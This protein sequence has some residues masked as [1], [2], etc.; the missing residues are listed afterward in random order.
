MLFTLVIDPLNSLLIH[1]TR[2][3]I[4]RRL[5]DRH[6]ASSV[7]L[8]ADDVVVF[9][10]PD[11]QQLHVMRELLWVFGVA[12][13]LHTNFRKSSAIPIKCSPEQ[14]VEIGDALVC[15]VASFPVT[16]LGLPLSIRN[17][18]TTALLPLVER[19]ARL[20]PTWRASLL[21][22]GERLALARHVLSATPVHLLLA[23]ALNATILKKINR[24]I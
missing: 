1:T 3:G 9:C 23:M 17:P 14:I 11:G 13:G 6:A 18:S 15:P 21:S 22:K 7:S 5:T 16:Y 10:H 8:Y 19:M 24:I 2:S 20:L 4:L 12:S